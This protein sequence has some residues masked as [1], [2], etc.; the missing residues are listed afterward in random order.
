MTTRVQ[1]D[2]RSPGPSVVS[3]DLTTLFAPRSVAILGASDDSSKWGHALSRQMLAAG[4]DAEIHLVNRNGSQVLGRPTSR[5]L[6]EA[7]IA[8]GEPLDLVAICV[9]AAG[10]LESIDDALSAGARAVVAITAGLG[11]LG[12]EGARIEAEAR[13]RVREHGAVMVGPNCLGVV[14]TTTRLQL[15]LELLPTGTVAVLSQSGN[16]VIDLADLMSARGLGVSRFVSLGNQS[17]LGVVDFMA[18]CVEHPGTTAVAVYA[19]DVVDGRAFIGAARALRAAGKPVVLLAPGRSA[20][21]SR[22]AASHTGSLTSAA[23]VVDAACAAAGVHRV[24]TPEQMVDLLAAFGSDRRSGGRRVAV[25]TDGGGHG[26]VAADA[27]VAAGLEVPLLGPALGQQ[28]SAALWAN[29]TVHNPVDLA[30]AGERDPASYAGALAALLGSDEVDAVLLTGYF[31]GYAAGTT[32]LAQPELAAAGEIARITAAQAK[33]VVVHTIFPHSPSCQVLAAAGIP[34]HRDVVRACRVV[35]GL[36]TRTSGA[37]LDPVDLPPPAVPLADTG[38][39]AARALFAGA[40][41]SFPPAV[42]IADEAQ[43][44]DALES[45]AVRFPV[46]LKAMG[47]MHKSDAGG[48]VLDIADPAAATTAYRDLIRR[49]DPPTVSVEEMADR[50]NGVELIVGTVWDPRFG[51]VL[52]VGLGGIFT[53]VMADTAFAIA[54]VT[55]ATARDMLLSIRGAP[56]LQGARGREPLDLDAVAALAARVSV[57]AA[58]HPELVELEINPVLC[59]SRGAVALDARAVPRTTSAVER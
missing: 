34:V 26:A 36:Q 49:L 2:A 9:P 41:I 15:S 52:M 18:A 46:V 39:A 37:T 3:R 45:G 38:Y 53:E 42:E 30:G 11:E 5:T 19:E 56:L 27:A 33:P 6:A 23:Q 20:A 50:D 35:A 29:S 13:N 4:S 17:D 10:F 40:G 43:M 21:A 48:V 8:N 14:D 55:T 47:L 57:V 25:V 24:E 44:H 59:S 28:L 54:P 32:R 58:E 1:M 22:G 31:G 16:V 51:P 7:R 12:A